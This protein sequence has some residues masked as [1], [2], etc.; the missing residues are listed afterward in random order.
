[1]KTQLDSEPS[2]QLAFAYLSPR[3]IVD[4]LEKAGQLT[5]GQLDAAGPQLQT[6]LSQPVTMSASATADEVSLDASAATSS[7]TPAPKESALLGDFPSDSWF[8]FGASEAGRAYGQALAQG[9]QAALPSTLGVDVSQIAKWA[10]DLGGFARG[11]SLFGLG[12][13]LV[14]QTSDEQASGQTLSQLQRVFSRN[15]SV[16]V[17]PLS[18]SGEQGFTVTPRGAPIQI[19]FVQKDGKVVVGLGS[20]SVNQVFSPS[21]TL[22]GSDVFKTATGAL[23]SDFS[24][25]MF[26]DF[27]PLFQL[28]DSF[29]QATSDPSYQQAKPYL[30]HLDYLIFGGRSQGSRGSVRVTLGLQDA[31]SQSGTVS[32]STPTAAVGSASR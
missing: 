6:L 9:G 16:S 18:E 28:V 3:A 11:T 27:V 19:Q 24:P 12:G 14:L 32:T 1:F 31:S 15:S 8:A 25:V 21:S 13:A 23:G 10:G 17:T 7:S 4:Q 22:G 2:D 5:A 26:L 20:D 29:P 30:E